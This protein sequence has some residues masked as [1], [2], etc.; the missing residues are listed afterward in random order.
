M[1]RSIWRVEA[2]GLFVWLEDCYQQQAQP[3]DSLS[4]VLLE[5]AREALDAPPGDKL[6]KVR[7]WWNGWH[8]ESVWRALHAAEAR[9]T[10]L[11]G[12]LAGRL[13]DVRARVGAHLPAKDDRYRALGKIGATSDA[14]VTAPDRVV[15]ETA[16][17]AAFKTADDSYSTLRGHRN[18]L[19]YTAFVLLALMTVIG[20][21]TS[22]RAGMLPLCG[23][24][25]CP[26]GG[27][28]GSGGDFWWVAGWGVFGALVAAT[29][30]GMKL[31]LSLAPY[32]YGVPLF[33]TK[34]ALGAG[35]AVIGVL[36]LKAGAIAGAKLDNQV[37]LIMAAIALGYSQQVGTRV[38]DSYSKKLVA[39]A[40][41]STAVTAAD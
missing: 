17:A 27:A 23:K 2:R 9:I 6:T 26:T 5:Q 34:L 38:L 37:A 13:P 29:V 3:R 33:I 16:L 8:K 24:G 10:S 22:L 11:G 36:A 28:S 14:D 21:V 35:I 4:G 20:V 12:D 40:K 30:T 7:T 1:S 41:P 39:E 25:V 18:R 31:K 19:L 15:I 32:A